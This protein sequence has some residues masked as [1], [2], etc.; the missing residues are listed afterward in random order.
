MKIYRKQNRLTKYNYTQPGFYFV[1]ICCD[2]KIEYFGQVKNAIM[3]LNDC[4]KIAEDFWKTIPKHY[5]NISL[6]EFVVMPN[7]MHG[8]IVIEPVV[9]ASGLLLSLSQIVGS[10]KNIVTKQI[11][12]NQL[13]EFS[14]Q[15]SFYDHVVRRDESLNKIREYIRS[16]PLKWELD[17]NNP[18]NLW[19]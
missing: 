10:Y 16:N 11:R 6:D 2:R 1:T 13:K 12:N 5:N 4:G 18:A 14:W 15:P 17:R 9:Q 7:H 19:M 8:I 3:V